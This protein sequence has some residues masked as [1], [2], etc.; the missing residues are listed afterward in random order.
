MPSRR[1]PPDNPPPAPGASE[2]DYER[3]SVEFKQQVRQAK[4]RISDRYAKLVGD[5]SQRKT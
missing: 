5:T 4:E 3:L 1:D 2:P